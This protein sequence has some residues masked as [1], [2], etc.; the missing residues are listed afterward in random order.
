MKE[1]QKT[2]PFQASFSSQAT[3]RGDTELEPS[4]PESRSL[5]QQLQVSWVLLIADPEGVPEVGS[6]FAGEKHISEGEDLRFH[7]RELEHKA[8][9]H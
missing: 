7:Y 4:Q 2:E 1:F 6:S 9:R 8:D 3:S 5:A